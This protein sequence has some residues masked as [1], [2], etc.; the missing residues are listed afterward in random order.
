MKR[1]NQVNLNGT[2]TPCPFSFASHDL[3]LSFPSPVP[4]RVSRRHRGLPVRVCLLR[5]LEQHVVEDPRDVDLHVVLDALQHVH[6][7][8]HRSQQLGGLGDLRRL[9]VEHHHAGQRAGEP[10]LYNEGRI[11]IVVQ[12]WFQKSPYRGVG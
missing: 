2:V 3:S 5:L 11:G 10:G 6:V 12:P 7:R 1:S 8:A 9:G 4:L